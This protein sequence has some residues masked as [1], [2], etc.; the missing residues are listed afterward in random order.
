MSSLGLVVWLIYT[1][2]RLLDGRTRARDDGGAFG[3]PLRQ[4]HF[5]H[6]VHARR[7][8]AVAAGAAAFTAVLVLTQI[9]EQVLKLSVPVGLILVLY[10]A[11]GAL[12]RGGVFLRLS[13]E[14]G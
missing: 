3:S 11:L 1:V 7:I 12:R 14:V 4:R 13:K 8:A 10:M 9:G 2:D 6:R 5:F